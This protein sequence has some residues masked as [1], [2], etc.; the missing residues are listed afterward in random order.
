M[1]RINVQAIGETVRQTTVA[2]EIE[3]MYSWSVL[4]LNRERAKKYETV[5]GAEDNYITSI[6][7][8]ISEK[9]S[10]NGSMVVQEFPVILEIGDIVQ[11]S[12]NY[13]NLF[14]G[15]ISALPKM[16]GGTVSVDSFL[17]KLN[18]I[19]Y[20]GT[21]SAKTN[22]EI[23]ETII[24][25]S[26]AKTG[27]LWNSALVNLV[28]T[29]TYSPSYADDTLKN[30]ITD[31]AE[32]EEDCYYGINGDGYFY[33]RKRDDTVSQTLYA[34]SLTNLS[35][36][37]DYTKINYTRIELYRKVSDVETFVSEIPDGSTYSYFGVED[38]IGIRQKKLVAP[39]ELSE[40]EA[41]LWA[42][43]EVSAQIQ[44]ATQ[45]K[46][47]GLNIEELLLRVGQK[48]RIYD[49]EN[50]C[51]DDTLVDTESLDNWTGA[52]LS[53]D[54]YMN[55]YS[56]QI[57]TTGIYILPSVLV[58]TQMQR[59]AFV[60]KA[61]TYGSAGE[62]FILVDSGA[63]YRITEAD[64]RV[65][66][67]AGVQMTTYNYEW[68]SLG[69]I[70]LS[71]PGLFCY[72]DFDISSYSTIKG[73]KIVATKTIKVDFFNFVWYNSKYYELNVESLQFSL[74][75]SNTNNYSATLGSHDN[76]ANDI[77]FALEKEIERRSS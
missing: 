40:S 31:W 66:S 67:E 3:P 76:S 34:E 46:I 30:I 25:A 47:S 61:E 21:F 6:N 63:K 54:A 33:V 32:S 45:I 69:E 57:A 41:K 14:V 12:Y 53:S 11:I 56:I 9:G 15:Y 13:T 36:S 44:T 22:K 58:S 24:V 37:E 8:E 71:S 23:L 39:D 48:I 70:F 74:T 55:D 28:S 27:L 77:Q 68:V 7:F 20:R 26:K 29:D 50:L 1:Y 4:I 60:C 65:I 38:I 42:Y 72:V 52:T 2:T 16:S 10:L 5:L 35:L 59:L 62:V 17:N 64:K 73:I 75:S 18:D 43:G 51:S 19:T 49:S